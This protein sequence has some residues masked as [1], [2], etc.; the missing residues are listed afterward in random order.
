MK[1]TMKFWPSKLKINILQ[2]VFPLEKLLSTDLSV[3]TRTKATHSLFPKHNNHFTPFIH[4]L[5]TIVPGQL[6]HHFCSRP[7]E[8]A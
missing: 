2:R 7:C 1:N 8:L 5:Q 3:F 4:G 6:D